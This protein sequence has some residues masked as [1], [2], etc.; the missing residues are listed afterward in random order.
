MAGEQP[1]QSA[2]D[3]QGHDKYQEQ[4]DD[5]HGREGISLDHCNLEVENF[6][7]RVEDFHAWTFQLAGIRNDRCREDEGLL[8]RAVGGRDLRRPG[9]GGRLRSANEG[10]DAEA[11]GG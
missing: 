2:G 6:P 8:R 9:T 11:R 1:G 3:K 4:L 7:D 5:A 10:W